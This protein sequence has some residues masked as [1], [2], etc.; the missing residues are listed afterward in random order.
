MKKNVIKTILALSAVVALAAVSSACTEGTEQDSIED[1]IQVSITI[2]YPDGSDAEDIVDQKFLV[3]EGTTVL[4][5]LQIYCN[6]HDIPV[7]VETTAAS[8]YGI[9]RIYNADEDET[10]GNEDGE[11]SEDDAARE[12]GDEA[13]EA[14]DTVS[15]SGTWSFSVN[16]EDSTVSENEFKLSDGDSVVWSYR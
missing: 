7:N 16:G 5:A 1:P 15:I 11:G 14:D 6:V 3:E 13:S 10:S 4:D 12:D 9:N 8:I 2:D